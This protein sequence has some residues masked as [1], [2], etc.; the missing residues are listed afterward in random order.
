MLSLRQSEQNPQPGQNWPVSQETK[1]VNM[2]CVPREHGKHDIDS[3][4]RKQQPVI[5]SAI[6]SG[7]P[8]LA[9]NVPI[10]SCIPTNNL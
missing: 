1:S 7:K 2:T 5:L 3:G 4:V 10:T 6:L 9:N 8:I